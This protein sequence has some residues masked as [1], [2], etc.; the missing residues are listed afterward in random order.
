MFYPDIIR[1]GLIQILAVAVRQHNCGF[2]YDQPF[3]LG[4]FL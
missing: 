3:L 4:L 2:F 1:E